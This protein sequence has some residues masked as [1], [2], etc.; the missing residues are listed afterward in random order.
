MKRLEEIKNEV[1]KEFGYESFEQF[2]DKSTFS[3]DH[4]TP[5]IIDEISKRYALEVAQASLQKADKEFKNTAVKSIG[6]ALDYFE[7]MK[8][9]TIYK[10]DV[11]SFLHAFYQF[12]AQGLSIVG[13]GYK[14]YDGKEITD[15]EGAYEGGYFTEKKKYQITNES[16]ITLL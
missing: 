16:N 8:N 9:E 4:K 13:M 12:E 7:E 10:R 2:D 11:I 3:Y 5:K 14:R 15:L 6:T 1:V